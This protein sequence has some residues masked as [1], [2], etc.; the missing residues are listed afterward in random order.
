MNSD[1]FSSLE[2]MGKGMLAIFVVIIAIYAVV[3][4]LLT[5]SKGKNSDN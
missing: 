5:V 1:F 4:I 2:L 3:N